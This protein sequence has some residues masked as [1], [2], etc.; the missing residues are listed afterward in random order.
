M[1]NVEENLRYVLNWILNNIPLVI[2]IFTFV[3]QITPIKWNPWTALFKWLGEK[4]TMGPC[5]KLDGLITKVNELD[6]SVMENEKDRIRWEVLN[7]ANS[8]RHN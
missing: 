3:I 8:C 4:I 6:K 2:I 7:F 1:M 5:S